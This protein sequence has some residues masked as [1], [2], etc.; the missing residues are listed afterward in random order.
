MNDGRLPTLVEMRTFWKYGFALLKN[1]DAMIKE[2]NTFIWVPVS[3]KDPRAVGGR[4]WILLGQ[5]PAPTLTSWIEMHNGSYPKWG[6]DGEAPEWKT[7]FA[8]DVGFFSPPT[9]GRDW[10][11]EPRRLTIIYIK[12]SLQK[13]DLHS[14]T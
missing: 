14:I 3:T 9:M 13:T 10:W 8:A 12:F 11:F 6:D 5:G 4:D 2:K 7:E 1:R